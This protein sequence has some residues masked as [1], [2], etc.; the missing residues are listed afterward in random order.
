[1]NSIKVDRFEADI[2]CYEALTFPFFGRM[3]VVER[4]VLIA[5]P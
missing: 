3:L 4:C 2:A 1:M 5:Q